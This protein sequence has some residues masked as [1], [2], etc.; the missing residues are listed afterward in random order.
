M[1]EVP[2]VLGGCGV[3]LGGFNAN[4]GHPTYCCGLVSLIKAVVQLQE[5]AVAPHIHLE[6]PIGLTSNLKILASIF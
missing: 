1:R 6:N 5:R 2:D 3:A 4:L